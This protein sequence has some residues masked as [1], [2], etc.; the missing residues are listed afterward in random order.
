MGGGSGDGGG[1]G[2][3]GGEEQVGRKKEGRKTKQLYGRKCNRRTDNRSTLIKHYYWH[4]H[5]AGAT[6]HR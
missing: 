2:G 1:G 4:Y 6:H 5:F 3:G